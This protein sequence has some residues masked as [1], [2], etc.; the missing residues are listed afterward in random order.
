MYL[1]NNRLTNFIGDHTNLVLSC[2]AEINERYQFLFLRLMSELNRLS[3]ETVQI[4]VYYIDV[5]EPTGI[6]TPQV[7]IMGKEPLDFGLLCDRYAQLYQR[8][9][10]S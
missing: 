8:A 5:D 9:I 3:S 1:D 2:Y 10:I 6:P 7:D 4:H